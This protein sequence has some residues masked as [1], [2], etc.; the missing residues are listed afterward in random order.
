MNIMNGVIHC[1]EQAGLGL[2][3][4]KYLY[5]IDMGRC[6]ASCQYCGTGIRY[7]FFLR[8]ADNREF[9]VGCDCIYKSGDLGLIDIAKK[10]RRRLAK[11]KRDALNAAKAKD[12]QTKW[13]TE[14]KEKL[15]I[16]FAKH[17]T[18]K[19]VFDWAENASGIALDLYNNLQKWGNLT[20]NQIA[21]LVRLY[22]DAQKPKAS[23]PTGKVTI[24]GTV[25]ST[26]WVDN[27]FNRYGNQEK[28]TVESSDGYRV[29]GT[30]PKSLDGV[31][32]GSKVRFVAT[33]QP[34]DKDQYFGF[35]NRPS[36]ATLME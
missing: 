10:E 19:P 27:Q 20:D 23:C 18:I 12:R 33:V 7:K 17:F 34:S 6:A 8:S 28:M 35:F 32:K 14:R 9:Y 21:L 3:P 2:A 5:C 4:F 36:E 13:E 25:V 30:V 31:T 15:E 1:F 26:K 16:F 24:E 11:E 29:F 22:D